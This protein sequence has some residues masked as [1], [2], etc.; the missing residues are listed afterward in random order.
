MNQAT[1]EIRKPRTDDRQIWNILWGSAAQRVTLVAHDLKL[2]SLLDK[3]PHSLVEV[4]QTLGIKDRPAF[5]ILSVLVSIGLAEV[6]EG[7]YTLTTLAEDYLLE[8]SPT[9]LGAILDHMIVQNYVVSSFESLKQAVL[10]DAPPTKGGGQLFDSFEEQASTA[11][12]FTYGMH[13]YSMGAALAWPEKIDL[14]EYKQ[15]LDIGGGSGAHSIGAALNWPSLKAVVLDLASVCEVA[16]EFVV[17]YG[18]QGRI[19][20]HV[21][22]MWRNPFPAADIHFYSNIYHDWP[23]EKAWFLTQ[24]SFD[25]LPSGGRIVLHEM[26]Y[27]DSKTEPKAI[28]FYNVVMLL[29]MEGQQYSGSELSA[30]LAEVGFVDIQVKPT[31][32]YWSIVTGRKP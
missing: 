13:G 7:D 4:C 8:T 26:L 31:T 18:L 32:G 21:S 23:P 6:R 25:S 15:M 17:S 28:A 27:E 1:V 12:T 19:E 5:A 2:F 10:T 20:T 29:R 22:D 11:R 30:M 3:C 16:Q 24:K 14:S 9:Y